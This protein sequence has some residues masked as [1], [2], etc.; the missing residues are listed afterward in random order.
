MVPK[1]GYIVKQYLCLLQAAWYEWISCQRPSFG[2]LRFREWRSVGIIAASCKGAVSHK[3]QLRFRTCKVFRVWGP[4]SETQICS[5]CT[6]CSLSRL[7]SQRT[8]TQVPRPQPRTIGPCPDYWYYH[9]HSCAD[10]Y[11]HIVMFI[12][13]ATLAMNRL[14]P[15]RACT[16]SA[17]TTAL[18][19]TQ[20][21]W[22]AEV[23]CPPDAD[24][25]LA[26][27]GGMPT[28]RVLGFRV[29]R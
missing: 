7:D 15:I 6:T 16:L 26:M 21:S 11:Y 28:W 20:L 27:L 22:V 10:H 2:G 14:N 19:S 17:K 24:A 13:V 8:T 4:K 1:N 23:K 5:H 12:I 25:V 3:V 29:W 18:S 9:Y